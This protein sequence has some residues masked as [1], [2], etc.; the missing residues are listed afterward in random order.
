MFKD[1]LFEIEKDLS[2]YHSDK[3]DLIQK[4]TQ[5]RLEISVQRYY[6]DIE[7]SFS[8]LQNRSEENLL[9]N[10]KRILNGK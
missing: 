5:E 6:K 3:K 7:K 10:Y 8:Y 1:V 2:K 9:R 4:Y